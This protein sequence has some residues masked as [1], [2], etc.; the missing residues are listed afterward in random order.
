LKKIINIIQVATVNTLQDINANRFRTFLSLLGIAI[1][2]FCMTGV[3]SAINSLA[4]NIN[5][6]LSSIGSNTLFISKWQWN[7]SS[8]NIKKIAARPS[9]TWQDY[10]AIKENAKQLQHACF[11]TSETI[12]L[13]HNNSTIAPVFMYASDEQFLKVQDLTLVTG[14][15]FSTTESIN[16]TQSVIIGNNIAEQLFGN[17]EAALAQSFLVKNKIVQVI[18]VLKKYGRNILQGWDFDNAIIVNYHFYANHLH[19]KRNESFIMAKPKSDVNISNF[20]AETKNILRNKRGLKPTD[21]DNF[22]IN[23]IGVFMNNINNIS[24]YVKFAGGFIAFFSLLVGA[25]GVAN[26]MYVAVKER[27]KL[28]GIKKA[29]GAKAKTIQLEILIE[30]VILC[31]IGATIGLLLLFVSVYF[32]SNLFGFKIII[33]WVELIFTFIITMCIGIFSGWFPAKSAAK[34]NP[35]VAIRS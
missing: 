3:L 29:I 6:D 1:G 34:L 13:E 15:L 12:T 35:V 19:N 31:L 17:A 21:E 22:S 9:V 4:Y 33:S 23:T 16:A 28:I 10:M 7:N 2:I 30:S 5:K 8:N 26:I 20:N 14:R 11:I 32:F 18:G 25:F 24:N 27:T